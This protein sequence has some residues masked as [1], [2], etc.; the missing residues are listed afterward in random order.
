ML[1][2][3]IFSLLLVLVIA[4]SSAN[5]SAQEIGELFVLVKDKKG[6]AVESG[7]LILREPNGV[8]PKIISLNSLKN[9]SIPVPAGEISITVRVPG[10]NE[11][12]RKV[13]IHAGR[14]QIEFIL[15]IASFIEEVDVEE[16]EK[17]KRLSQ[18][19]SVFLGP[20]EISKLPES[21]EAIKE[22]LGKRF[23]DD[24]IILI[25]GNPSNGNFP[26][27]DQI[28]SIEVIKN[29]F[30]AQFHEI[31]K[32]I[33]N[34]RTKAVGVS[35]YGSFIGSIN[36]WIFNSRKPL[37]SQ[38]GHDYENR[39]LGFFGIPIKKGLS[40][41]S[42]GFALSDSF[43]SVANL[44][45]QQN[46]ELRR[47]R[48]FGVSFIT[49]HLAYSHLIRNEHNLGIS[50]SRSDRSYS[51]LGPLDI[52]SRKVVNRNVSDSLYLTHAGSIGKKFY[53][54]GAVRFGVERGR[55][56]SA[57]SE[58]GIV[59]LNTVYA[60]GS[61]IDSSNKKNDFEFRYRLQTAYSNHSFKFGTKIESE[62]IRQESN[63]NLNGQFIFTSYENYLNSR[64]FQYSKSLAQRKV[65]L[66]QA[67]AAFYFQDYFK[68]NKDMQL[69]F[70]VRYEM[71]SDVKDYNNFS[72]RIGLVFSPDKRGKLVLRTN[73]GILYDWLTSSLRASLLSRGVDNGGTII[74]SNPSYPNPDLNDAIISSTPKSYA[75]IDPKLRAPEIYLFLINGNYLLG[76]NTNIDATLKVIRGRHHFR[77]R[78][79]NSPINGIRPNEEFGRISFFESSGKSNISSID[80]KLNHRI[81]KTDFLANYV[82]TQN[83]DDF[84]SATAL[85]S[86]SYDLNADYSRSRLEL[87]NKLS[88]SVSPPKFYGITLSPS[89]VIES[90]YPYNSITGR[91]DNLDTVINDRRAGVSRNSLRGEWLYSL[92][93]SA[94]YNLPLK[95]IGIKRF[96]KKSINLRVNG[97]NLL[98]TSNLT[99][100]NGNELS[101][102]YNQP[103]SSRRPRS[104]TFSMSVGF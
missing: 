80:L 96:E 45:N 78:D 76:K 61:G 49:G 37:D 90:G 71:Q 15:S 100:Y 83:M 12:S 56:T 22:E 36:N 23:G 28:A 2:A 32:T 21:G 39:L 7:E 25:D 102:Y 4:V 26:S 19:F 82:W 59:V 6:D 58:T 34:I 14:N 48:G 16:T 54:D 75:K 74:I 38:K 84:D 98:N 86:D 24:A 57:S 87:T 63:N 50:L 73:I 79:I 77:T 47:K 8:P 92:D 95:F 51:R 99:N 66:N 46:D 42:M 10:F 70:G 31:G 89:F 27:R 81:F 65:A 41:V 93:V 29:S 104:F 13:K 94:G 17:E 5:V 69:S 18:A 53:G 33:F 35:S 103:T 30:D 60:G 20:E 44:Q 91:D 101:P 85:P 1:R 68:P 52:E 3:L 97:V 43:N 88:L 55:G 72:P 67:R 62:S 9:D 64:P 11:E 40:G